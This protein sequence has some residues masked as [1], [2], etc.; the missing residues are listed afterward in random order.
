MTERQFRHFFCFLVGYHI[1]KLMQEAVSERFLVVILYKVC[2]SPEIRDFFNSMSFIF[3]PY[4]IYICILC[5]QF[6][7]C[8]NSPCHQFLQV[9]RFYVIVFCIPC[10]PYV[11]SF[12]SS[13]LLKEQE[14]GRTGTFIYQGSSANACQRHKGRIT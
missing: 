4:V 5:H 3:A 12:C 1:L 6:L 9:S 11:I 14:E 10:F 8:E 13:F 7:Q 2:F